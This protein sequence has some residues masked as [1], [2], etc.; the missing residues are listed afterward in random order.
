MRKLIVSNN[1]TL[2]GRVGEVRDWAL[3]GDDDEFVKH[4]T[5]LLSHS[6]GL[7]LGRGTYEFFAAVWPSRSGAFPDRMNSIA[8]HVAS[9]TLK[10][11]AWENSH[12]IE[13]E[14]PEAVAKLKQQP[15]QDLVVYGSNDLMHSLL[16]H[17]L[18]DEY[19]LWV[20]P[21]V[22]GSGRSLF[23]DGV[24]RIDLDLVD[25]TVIPPGVAILTYHPKR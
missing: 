18:I 23:K 19:Q 25:T 14:V 1:V 24:E 8:K 7:L 3:R 21:V 6:D 17:D 5:D 2:D 12:L 22:L 13:G 20:Y 10:E 4:Q 9:T 16:E 11:L 15:G